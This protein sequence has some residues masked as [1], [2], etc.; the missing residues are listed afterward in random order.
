MQQYRV[1]AESNGLVDD[2]QSKGGGGGGGA[3]MGGG[4]GAGGGDGG[5][6]NWIPAPLDWQVSALMRRVVRN[7]GGWS[8]PNSR[9]IKVMTPLRPISRP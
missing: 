7:I 3:A 9:P 1:F 6:D 2:G 8:D 5:G 4:G